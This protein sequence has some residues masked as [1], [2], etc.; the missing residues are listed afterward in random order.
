V[1]ALEQTSLDGLFPCPACHGVGRK[2]NRET[3]ADEPCRVCE[4]TGNVN[5][6]PGDDSFGY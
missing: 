5:Y 4:A 2:P 6:D 1:S 3:G